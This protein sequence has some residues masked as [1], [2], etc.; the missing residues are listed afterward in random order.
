MRAVTSL[1]RLLRNSTTHVV[2]L[3]P[4][5]ETSYNTSSQ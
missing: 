5:A 3:V 4:I 1:A 2:E